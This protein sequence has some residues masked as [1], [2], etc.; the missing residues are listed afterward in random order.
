MRRLTAFA[1][2]TA[3][4]GL[5]IA[6]APSQ[7]Q[8]GATRAAD[9]QPRTRRDAPPTGCGFLGIYPNDIGRRTA[10]K[11]GLGER[12]GAIVE[13]IVRET[14]ASRAG[15]LTNDVITAFNGEPVSGEEQ[16]RRLIMSQAPGAWVRL[17]VLRNGQ[18]MMI[19]AEIT[20]RAKYFGG[21]D[22]SQTPSQQPEQQQREQLGRDREHDV[23]LSVLVDPDLQDEL[24]GAERELDRAGQQLRLSIEGVRVQRNMLNGYEGN[25]GLGLQKLSKQLAEYF[26]TGTDGALVNEVAEDSPA[27]RAGM[28]AG[29]VIVDVNGRSVGGPMDAVKGI[30]EDRDGTVDVTFVRDGQERTV[31]IRTG[32]SGSDTLTPR[33]LPDLGSRTTTQRGTRLVR[34]GAQDFR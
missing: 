19:N 29:D 17:D 22:C 21:P 26:R 16:L 6:V 32:S 34:G 10:A 7:A 12:R 14:G 8:Q 20:A 18:T 1:L 27:L 31:Q 23:D 3:L 4:F 24:V 28:Q 25:T 9:E 5:F 33:G 15:I 30:V 13:G 11:L 2:V